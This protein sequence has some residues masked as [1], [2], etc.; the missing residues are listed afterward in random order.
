MPD[1]VP[2]KNYGQ[3]L[4]YVGDVFYSRYEGR[5]YNYGLTTT[6][7]MIV[8]DAVYSRADRPYILDELSNSYKQKPV[9]ILRKF[10]MGG[11]SGKPQS[12]DRYA[13]CALAGSWTTPFDYEK[14]QCC[15][16]VILLIRDSSANDIDVMDYAGKLLYNIQELPSYQQMTGFRFYHEPNPDKI[17]GSLNYGDGY[18]SISNRKTSAF[19]N[20]LTGSFTLVDCPLLLGFSD[21]VAAYR[22]GN[23]WGYLDNNSNIVISP[24]Y[25]SAEKFIDGKAIVELS[26]SYNAVID[27]SGHILFRTTRDIERKSRY[28]GEGFHDS[29]LYAVFDSSLNEIFN[30]S[31]VDSYSTFNGGYSYVKNKKTTVLYGDSV[32]NIAGEYDVFWVQNN[33]VLYG[34]RKKNQYMLMTLQGTLVAELGEDYSRWTILHT[35]DRNNDFILYYSSGML[36]LIDNPHSQTIAAGDGRMNLA[37]GTMLFSVSNDQYFA[38]IDTAGR[39][40]FRKSLLSS[41]P[42]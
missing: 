25:K 5:F 35:G 3:L 9:Y 23:F 42:D 32:I 38:Y 36:Y 37:D 28:F 7:G 11:T 30:L 10:V 16:K 39:T 15:D 34:I 8:T 13:V 14:V 6:S 40:V 21:G 12:L 18:I 2:S 41:I 22:E 29:N 31:Y 20:E 1:L 24:Q 17:A 33:Y 26:D 19:F 27:K 4:P